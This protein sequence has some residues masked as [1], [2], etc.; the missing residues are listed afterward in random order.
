MLVY[1]DDVSVVF[2]RRNGANKKIAE[3]YGS[4]VAAKLE[5]RDAAATAEPPLRPPASVLSIG[6]PFEPLHRGTLFALLGHYRAALAEYA[7]ALERNA[8]FYQ[9]FYNISLVYA[10]QEAYEKALPYARA[11][12]ALTPR[13]PST[14]DHLASVLWKAG[15]HGEARGV[16][17]KALAADP[18]YIKAYHDLAAMHLDR[19]S[20]HEALV[21]LQSASRIRPGIPEIHA[22]MAVALL[23]LGSNGQ[24]IAEA[25]ESVRLDPGCVEGY[26][27]LGFALGR[28]GY[29]GEAR[30]AYERALQLKPDDIESLVNLGTCC[31]RLGHREAARQ[32]WDRARRLD[33]DDAGI[34]DNLRRLDDI[35]HQGGE[36]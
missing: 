13:S 3:R 28:A 34:Q 29:Q 31:A 16:F 1:C 35:E 32:Y 9:T 22:A 25:K 8:G 12:A 5:E 19:G 7:L 11:A 27:A 4:L 26:R 15:E 36:R 17:Q 18:S 10:H 30:R 14:L 6:I 21:V 33:P 23:G 24:A 20:V 2:V